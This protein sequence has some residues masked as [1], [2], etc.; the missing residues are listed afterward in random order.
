[1]RLGYLLV[2]HNVFGV[3]APGALFDVW[4]L[5]MQRLVRRR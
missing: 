5:I 1:M 2:H 4:M 3:D